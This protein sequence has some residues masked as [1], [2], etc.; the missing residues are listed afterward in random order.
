MRHVHVTALSNLPSEATASAVLDAHFPEAL[1]WTS[2]IARA[3]HEA[4]IA[5]ALARAAAMSVRALLGADWL[6]ELSPIRLGRLFVIG[7]AEIDGSCFRHI[8][9]EAKKRKKRE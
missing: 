4:D 6:A 7:A 8:L 5:L 2:L 9:S 3:A 1:G